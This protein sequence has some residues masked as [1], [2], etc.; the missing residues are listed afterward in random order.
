MRGIKGRAAVVTGAGDGIGRGV[1]IRLAEEGAR[2]L[3]AD[4]NFE[5]AQAVADHIRAQGGEAEPCRADVSQ[6]DQVEA[7]VDSALTRFGSADILVNNAWGGGTTKRLKD[8]TDADFLRGFTMS[9]S[10][11]HWAML[12]AFPSMK[13]RG[14][15]RIVS[16]CSLNGVN[17]H[18]YTAEYNVGKEALRALTRTAAREWAP[19][20]ICANIVCPGA[21]SAAYARFEQANPQAAALVAGQNPMGWVGD[22]LDDIA[23]VVAFLASDDCRYMTGNTLFVDGGSHIN[24]VAWA[25]QL[26]DEDKG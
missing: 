21:K 7:M 26:P 5:N 18:L 17:A 6:R 16:M 15:G 11:A 24:G 25:P 12:R 14:W 23:P 8:K 13:E 20:G 1:A 9:V 3:V 19:F 2:V 10:A 22:P 4:I